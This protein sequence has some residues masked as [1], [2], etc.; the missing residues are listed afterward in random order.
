MLHDDRCHVGIAEQ[1]EERPPLAVQRRPDL[2][3]DPANGDA[4]LANPRREPSDVPVKIGPLV[5]G[6]HPRIHHYDVGRMSRPRAS[7]TR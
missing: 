3:H 1:R 2:G 4:L 6:R 5:G 7:G